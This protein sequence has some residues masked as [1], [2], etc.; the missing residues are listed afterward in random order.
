MVTSAIKTD[1][2]T[3]RLSGLSEVERGEVAAATVAIF[4]AI[5]GRS[6]AVQVMAVVA[7]IWVLLR[8]SDLNFSDA[9]GYVDRMSRDEVHSTRIHRTFA[10]L[11]DYVKSDVLRRPG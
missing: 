8:K 10:G 3:T 6:R 11:I 4:D 2:T 1:L 7:A 5:K 9:M